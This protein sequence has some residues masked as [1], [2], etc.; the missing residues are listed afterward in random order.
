MPS[1]HSSPHSD[2]VSLLDTARLA[3]LTRSQIAST[4]VARSNAA[5]V[6]VS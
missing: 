3:R 1:V 6:R 2:V 4:P 5:R